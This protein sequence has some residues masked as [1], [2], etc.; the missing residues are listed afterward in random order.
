MS[1]SQALPIE[2]QKN[3][4]KGIVCIM[5]LRSPLIPCYFIDLCPLVSS[6]RY[7]RLK[8]LKII[9]VPTVRI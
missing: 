1:D 7:S 4:S 2:S 5:I 8:Y 3:T 9:T 6:L